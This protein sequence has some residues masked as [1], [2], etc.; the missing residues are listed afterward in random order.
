M[1]GVKPLQGI[2][3]NDV[4]R[5]IETGERLSKPENCPRSL[6]ELMCNCWTFEPSGRPQ[7][8]YIKKRLL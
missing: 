4:I 3:N 5:K 2:K 7:F 6:Y 1:F 8:S